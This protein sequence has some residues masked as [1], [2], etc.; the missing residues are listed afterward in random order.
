MCE[1]NEARA[2]AR[3][4]DLRKMNP[5]ETIEGR[6]EY[7]LTRLEELEKRVD[8]MFRGLL[9]YK[10][11]Q[12][13]ESPSAPVKKQPR[14]RKSRAKP[15]TVIDLT[16]LQDSSPE[17]EAE[18]EV[19]KEAGPEP[20]PVPVPEAKEEEEAT[21][22]AEM[23]ASMTLDLLRAARVENFTVVHLDVNHK[24]PIGVGEGERRVGERRVVMAP[25]CEDCQLIECCCEADRL[26]VLADNARATADGFIQNEEGDWVR[27]E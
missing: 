9:T 2:K 27:E 10:E 8:D 23:Q 4:E 22:S 17:K 6:L 18:N 5:A 19:E 24:D 15:N 3:Y 20:V 26:Q 12:D 1:D 11:A 13:K 14:R 16:F 25:V 21:G 7:F